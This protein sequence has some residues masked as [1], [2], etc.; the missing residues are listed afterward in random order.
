MS[1]QKL[2]FVAGGAVYRRQLTACL[3]PVGAY[4]RALPNLT[5][6]KRE[7]GVT[8][9]ELVVTVVVIGILL[10]V[11]IPGFQHMIGSNRLTTST[12]ELVLAVV[13]ARSEAIRRNTTVQVCGMAAGNGSGALATACDGDSPGALYMLD[14]D[15]TAQLLRAAPALPAGTTLV[16]FVAMRYSGQ[17][18]GRTV[19]ATSP[20]NGLVADLHSAQLHSANHRCIYMTTGSSLKTCATSTD[21]HATNEPT[22]CQ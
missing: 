3:P 6:M 14:T 9:I 11:G 20:H 4:N 8:L 12:N 1:I 5:L 13:E 16:N 2:P 7:G 19:N 22:G 15:G 21:C 18:I 17:G 10:A